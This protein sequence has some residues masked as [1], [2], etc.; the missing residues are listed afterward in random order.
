VIVRTP[1]RLSA[2]QRELLEQMAKLDG[3]ETHERGLFDRVKDI[4]GD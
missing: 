1:R 3:E 4:F 2:Q